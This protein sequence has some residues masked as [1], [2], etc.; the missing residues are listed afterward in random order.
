MTWGPS[1]GLVDQANEDLDN[2]FAGSILARDHALTAKG[3]LF[4]VL[5]NGHGNV[6][7]LVNRLEEIAEK[8]LE[9][10]EELYVI[11]ATLAELA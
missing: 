7:P 8:A 4:A 2:A 11:K 1:Q 5:A 6:Q 10:Q 3:K 9:V